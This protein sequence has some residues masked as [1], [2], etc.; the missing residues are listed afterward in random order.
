MVEDSTGNFQKRSV[1]TPPPVFIINEKQKSTTNKP[2][3][4]V[5]FRITNPI[6]YIKYWWKKIMANEGID[7]R[8]KVRPITAIAIAVV[9]FSLAFG[10]GGVVLPIAIPGLKINNKIVTSTSTP[11]PTPIEWEETA[12]KGTLSKTSSQPPK[13]YLITSTSPKAITLQVPENI[14]L[15]PLVGK[16][17]LAVGTYNSKD[18]ILKVSDVQDLEVLSTTPVPIPTT[19]P[20]PSPTPSPTEVPTEIPTAT[21]TP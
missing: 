2:P 3:D 6:V 11:T 19:T 13:F 12:L 18:K 17:I 1:K 21:P 4:L 10:L 9:A 8:L 5:N 20:T 15:D 16:R 14:N 7:F